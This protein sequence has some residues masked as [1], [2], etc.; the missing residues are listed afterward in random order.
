MGGQHHFDAFFYEYFY[1]TKYDTPTITAVRTSDK[2]LVKYP[3]HDEWT[4]LFD[5]AVDPLETRNL[6][7]DKSHESLMKS[8]ADLMDRELKSSRFSIHAQADAPASAGGQ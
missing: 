5:L 4:E 1:E 3:G 2:K 6:A 8:M 7:G